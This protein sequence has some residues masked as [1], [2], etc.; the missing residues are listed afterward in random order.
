VP[1]CLRNASFP[2]HWEV[3]LGGVLTHATDTTTVT[4]D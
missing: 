1:P 4:L 3:T 2:I